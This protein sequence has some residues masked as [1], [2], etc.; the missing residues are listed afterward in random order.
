MSDWWEQKRN[1]SVVVDNESWILPAAQTLVTACTEYG[2][3]A[4]L[5]RSH[6]DIMEGGVAFYLAALK[7]HHLIF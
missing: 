2:D 1:I 3:N 7:S 6:D 5:C 4:K